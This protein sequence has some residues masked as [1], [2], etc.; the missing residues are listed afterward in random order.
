MKGIKVSLRKIIIDESAAEQRLDR[1]L[2]KLFPLAPRGEV[3]RLIRKKDVRINGKKAQVDSRIHHGDEIS[4]FISQ[5]KEEDWTR[6]RPLPKGGPLK[7]IFEDE[8]D[9]V[10]FKAQGLK[11]TPDRLGESCLT[12]QVQAY[13]KD[14]ITATFRPS[15][16]G[17]LDKDTQGLVLFAKTYARSRELE[18]LQRKQEVG[19]F[20]LALVKGRIK[21]G[22]CELELEKRGTRPGVVERKGA[23]LA[24]T[25]FRNLEIKGGY[26]LVEA[27]L[28]TGRTHQI[29]ASIAHL[30]ASIVGDSLYG[31][32]EGGQE[33]ICYKLVWQDKSCE[34]ISQEFIDEVRK[35]GLGERNPI[36]ADK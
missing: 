2:F 25:I 23:K 29:R 17:R 5:D 28:I 9:L 32:L 4:I 1:Y 22:L 36:C 14:R 18:A 20:Y 10:V 15:P 34:F 3:Y 35:V 8:V 21:E 19:K 24:K 33:L 13:L 6:K 7:I 16:L 26:S 27:Q 31:R 12:S 30:G 11:T